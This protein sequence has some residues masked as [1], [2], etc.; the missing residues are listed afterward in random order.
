MQRHKLSL[1]V[2]S[3]TLQIVLL[4]L[5]ARR[6]DLWSAIFLYYAIFMLTLFIYNVFVDRN[7]T[8]TRYAVRTFFVPVIGALVSGIIAGYSIVNIV[9]VTLLAIM[10]SSLA[11]SVAYHACRFL[12]RNGPTEKGFD[13]LLEAGFTFFSFAGFILVMAMPLIL[14][15]ALI[16]FVVLAALSAAAAFALVQ[17]FRRTGTLIDRTLLSD[18]PPDPASLAGSAH[19][20]SIRLLSD[21]VNKTRA[22][23]TSVGGM[24]QQIRTLSEDLSAAS[25][26]M[27]ASLEEVSSTIQ[28]IAKG[29]QDQSSAITAI[30]QS[31]EGLNKLTTGISSQVKMASV[32]SQKTTTSAKH[33][34]ELAQKEA[35]LSKDIFGETRFIE[36]KMIQLREQSGEI[37]KILDIIAGISEQTDLLAINAAIEAA[38]VGEQGRGFAVV[39]DE[40]RNLATETKRSSEI[41]ESLI[42][43]INK[44]IQELGVLLTSERDKTTESNAL[45][46]ESE[47]QYT[48]IVKAVDVVFDMI[49]RI[50][51]AAA[52]QAEN[53]RNLVERVEQIARV[54]G[55]T[56][57][58]TEEVSAAVQEQTASME[59]FTSTAQ[60]L[61]S[62]A[63]KLEKLLDKHQTTR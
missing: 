39:A 8:L 28:H 51:Q 14:P 26:E 63:V 5:L 52:H 58:S 30:A 12:D 38:R 32:S 16:P 47:Q 44:T 61:N 23:F 10:S 11:A 1:S 22:T 18:E 45:A 43:E 62:F 20:G 24:G 49:S 56:A 15:G 46:A 19:E 9:W 57:S 31:I 59:E 21:F 13:P 55:E 36:D 27:N 6:L 41:V 50:N 40:I 17:P 35:Q 2:L 54:A 29:A 3:I 53:T 42:M 7:P 48:G 37:K 34:M 60:I 33:G 4:F 25:E